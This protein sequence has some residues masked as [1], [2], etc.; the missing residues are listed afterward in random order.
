MEEEKNQVS[1]GCGRNDAMF[2]MKQAK[3]TIHTQK[4]AI[5]H[6]SFLYQGGAERVLAE[7]LRLFPQADVY[8]PLIAPQ[9]LRVLRK[10]HRVFTSPLN[11]FPVP[12]KYASFLKPFVL[13]YWRLIDTRN[14]DLVISSSHSFSSKSVRTHAPTVHISYIHTPPKYLYAEKNEMH[15]IQSPFFQKIFRPFFTFLRKLDRVAAQ[16]IDLLV[17]NSHTTQ[18]RIR[19]YYGLSSTVIYPPVAL[20]KTKIAQKK[21][22]H[23]LFHSRLVQQKG[24]ELVV[25][26]FNELKKPLVIVGT[27]SEEKKLKNLAQKHKN[28]SFAG[29]VSDAKL[30]KIYA[31]TKAL[32][33]AAQDEDFGLVAVEAMA[34]G[35]PVIALR[36]G[37]FAESVVQGKTG[38]LFDEY[39]LESLTQ[40]VKD[41]EGRK[42]SPIACVQRA[43]KFSAPEFERK[44]MKLVHQ[45]L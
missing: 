26:A 22:Q 11:L 9:Y 12:E 15:W 7:L 21:P 41:F 27:G 29:F 17:A 19:Q 1:Y 38:L 18:R 10:N 31:H 45:S 35:V 20:P 39:S 2:I 33:L 32:V 16:R 30:E 4:V 6:D 13:L 43:E 44:F 3:K 36:S 5:V 40:A 14:Y 28:I 25:R 8:I 42:W 24:G 37:G 23:Y 34:R